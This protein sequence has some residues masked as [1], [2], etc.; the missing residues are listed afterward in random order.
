MP[1]GLS[2]VPTTAEGYW[3][4]AQGPTTVSY[5]GSVVGDGVDTLVEGWNLVAFPGDG[6]E[7]VEANPDVLPTFYEIQADSSYTPVERTVRPGRAY[8]VFARRPTQLFYAR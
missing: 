5:T 4:Y 3:V 2:A 1:F 6:P 7:V 8:W